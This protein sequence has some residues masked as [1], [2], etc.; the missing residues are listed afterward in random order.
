M[1]IGPNSRLY[2]GWTDSL[3]VK[4]RTLR[5]EPEVIASV[6]TEPVLVTKAARDSAL[7][8]IDGEM[9]TLIASGLPET[10]PA[11][12]QFLVADD[13]RIWIKRPT[14]APDAETVP[15]WVLDPETQTI[16]KTRLPSAVSL[17]VVTDDYTYGTTQTDLGA[18]A[19][20]RYRIES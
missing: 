15:W 20:V 6:P 9:R 19:V 2:Y 1:H 5:G 11:F 18:P 8:D 13:G 14:E 4:A 12:T 10:K 3:H 16:Y 17:T 7:S